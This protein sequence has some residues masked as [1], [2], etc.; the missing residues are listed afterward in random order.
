MVGT[1]AGRGGLKGQGAHFA[2]E[3]IATDKV[4]VPGL[5]AQRLRRPLLQLELKRLVPT[6]VA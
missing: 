3:I 2:Q 5:H 1:E 6:W 4:P